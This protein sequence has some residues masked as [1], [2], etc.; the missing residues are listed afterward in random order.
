MKYFISILFLFLLCSANNVLVSQNLDIQDTIYTPI[1]T[2]TSPKTSLFSGR[3]GKAALYSL[4]LPGAGQVYNK[5]IW[6]VPLVYGALAGMGGIVL[7]NRKKYREFK[8]VYIDRVDGVEPVAYPYYD[9]EGIR[10]IRNGYRKNLEL[11]Y[12]GFA[13]VWVLNAAEAFVDAHLQEF[14]MSEDISLQI[15]PDM[16]YTVLG[17]GYYGISFRFRPKR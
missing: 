16:D 10:T 7:F 11:S 12:I 6:K 3:P 8:Q 17:D 4:L 2:S 15:S 14:D 13:F 9:L 1:D 5:K